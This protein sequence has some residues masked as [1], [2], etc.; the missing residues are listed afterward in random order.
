M[1]G[2]IGQAPPHLGTDTACTRPLVR[3]QVPLANVVGQRVRQPVSRLPLRLVCNC[4]LQSLGLGEHSRVCTLSQPDGLG[5]GFSSPDDVALD[6]I[7]RRRNGL[8]L[9]NRG[10]QG[11]PYKP[12]TFSRG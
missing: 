9:V 3:G 7:A 5:K 2:E 1:G 11:L 12:P 4:R 6:Y 8:R 10:L